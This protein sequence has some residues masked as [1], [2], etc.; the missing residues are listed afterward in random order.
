MS[1]VYAQKNLTA[2]S[3]FA[4]TVDIL[5]SGLDTVAIQLEGTFSGTVVFEVTTDNDTWAALSVTPSAGGSAVTSATGTGI[6]AA[7][8]C[9]GYYAARARHSVHNSGTVIASIGAG[10][11]SVA[12]VANASDGQVLFM[13]GTNPIGDSG[14][15]F[16]SATNALTQDLVTATPRA[17]GMTWDF[18]TIPNSANGVIGWTAAGTP[19]VIY[20][21]GSTGGGAGAQIE[22]DLTFDAI[23]GSLTHG[24]SFYAGKTGDVGQIQARN[25]GPLYLDANNADTS[26]EVRVRVLDT[27]AGTTRAWIFSND[28]AVQLPAIA[29]AQLPGSPAAGMMAYIT[30]SS[31]QT[32]GATI[33]AAS[34]GSPVL[35]WYNGTNWTVMG[36]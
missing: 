15:T 13:S 14:L 7:N 11:D 20:Q 31:T 26:G 8:G 1:I 32:W 17:D 6:W 33:S 34:P 10:A 36:K 35:G 27:N 16:D 22:L 25:I 28:G 24:L 29:F 30:N 12:A 5:L 18:G 2:T 23:D 4:S 9:A 19:E 3:G 21:F